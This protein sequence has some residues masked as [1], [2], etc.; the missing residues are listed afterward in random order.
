[1]KN[2]KRKEKRK[3]CYLKNKV[4]CAHLRRADQIVMVLV[5]K[6]KNDPPTPKKRFSSNHKRRIM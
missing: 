5:A 4:R 2:E 1:M 6:G 3:K